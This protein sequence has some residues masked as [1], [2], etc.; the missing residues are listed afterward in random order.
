VYRTVTLVLVDGSGALLGALPPVT[1]ASPFW[2]EVADVV[3]A[4]RERFGIEVTILRLLG[5]ERS[6]PHGGA[7]TYLGQTDHAPAELVAAPEVNLAPH[8]LRAAYAEIGGPAAS[9]HWAAACLHSAAPTRAVRSATQLRTWNL[10]SIWRL[11][12][13]DGPVWL[14]QVPHFLAHEAAA[15]R[16]A[17]QAGTVPTV[18]AAA[19][20]RMLLDHVPGADLYGAGVET[21]HAI[22]AEFHPIQ[23]GADVDALLAAGVPDRRSGP[24]LDAIAAVAGRRNADLDAL[25]AGLPQRFA[26][27][28]ACGLPDTLV[29][30]DL[31]PG[32]VRGDAE[33]RTIID[34]GDSFIGHPAFDILRLAEGV[35]DP[36]LVEAWAERWRADVPGSDPLRAVEL[37]RPVAALRSATVYANFLANI[38]PTERPY[39]A[40]DVDAC[41][42]AALS[43]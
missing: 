28:E 5:A 33:H 29:H 27:I 22:A 1:V 42:A 38:E 26:A 11:E 40:G 41:L 25:V 6:A 24:L 4:A 34:W 13:G 15:L 12:T 17:G 23:A 8:P 18:L 21:R 14:K 3:D 30:G 31:H 9:V 7:V 35:D 16:Y 39:H 2:Q 36:G 19:D 10:S 32:N 37:V 20:G 43:A